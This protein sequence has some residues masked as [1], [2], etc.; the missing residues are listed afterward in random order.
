MPPG[1]DSHTE[2]GGPINITAIFE[3]AGEQPGRGERE[4]K[5]TGGSTTEA[6]LTTGGQP[7]LSLDSLQAY[8]GF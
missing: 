8:L 3:K 1:Q 2:Q 4:K 7:S 6:C 5:V